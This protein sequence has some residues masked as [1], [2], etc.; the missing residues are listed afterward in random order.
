MV[1]T[2]EVAEMEAATVNTRVPVDWVQAPTSPT[3]ALSVPPTARAVA[4]PVE[5]PVRPATVMV[6]PLGIAIEGVKVKVMVLA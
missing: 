1:R 4:S 5:E 3:L 2:V 6:R